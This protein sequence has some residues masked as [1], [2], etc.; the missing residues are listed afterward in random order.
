V[1]ILIQAVLIL[2]LCATSFADRR[3]Y[4]WTYAYQT[5]PAGATELE[6]YQTS[7]L[8]EVDQWE[9]RIEIE[10]GLTRRWDMSI[11]EIFKQDEGGSLSWDAV[12]WRTRIRFGE[13]GQ[14]F[15]DPLLY[16]EYNRKTDSSKPNKYE[17]KIILAKTIDRFNMA[18]NPVYELFAG[19]GTEHEVGLDAG[20]SWQ[21][22]PKL[23][24]GFESTTRMEFEDDETET[25]S[26]FGPTISFASGTWWYAAGFAMGLTDGSDDARIRFLMGIDL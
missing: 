7:K 10:H 25:S 2:V 20:F 5:M 6:F 4:V 26:Y 18:I 1:K 24:A 23:I 19:P 22:H 9:Y 3:A 21:F 12:Q 11:Y 17:A 14:Y 13:E 15:M 16:L 8:R